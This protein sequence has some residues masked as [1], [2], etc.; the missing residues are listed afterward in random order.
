[1]PT[2]MAEFHEVLVSANKTGDRNKLRK[3]PVLRS[4]C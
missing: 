4:F 3:N 2:P 1:M